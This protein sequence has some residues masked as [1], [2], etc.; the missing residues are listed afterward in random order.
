[1]VGVAGEGI[2]RMDFGQE[3]SHRQKSKLQSGRERE[4]GAH[5]ASSVVSS[6][7]FNLSIPS[8]AHGEGTLVLHLRISKHLRGGEEEGW[9][10]GEPVSWKQMRI[11]HLE[12]AEDEKV[13][14]NA[15]MQKVLQVSE[16]HLTGLL[17]GRGLGQGG[18]KRPTVKNSLLN[19][20]FTT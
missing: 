1:V 16:T 3:R 9:G 17:P 8:F 13:E 7:A 15:E 10:D 6:M 19:L 12:I 18:H 4:G 11:D 14:G 2:G 20:C 5:H